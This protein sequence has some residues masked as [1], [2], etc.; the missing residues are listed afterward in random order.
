MQRSNIPMKRAMQL[1]KKKTITTSYGATL[2]RKKTDNKIEKYAVIT[3]SSL[4]QQKQ[5]YDDITML[6][7]ELDLENQNTK[8]VFINFSAKWFQTFENK[9]NE[10][11]SSF[12]DKTD[13]L[14]L[15][16]EQFQ[17][18][19]LHLFEHYVTIQ[20]ENLDLKDQILIEKDQLQD[21]SNELDRL[22][23]QF[24]SFR[25]KSQNENQEILSQ[26]L[27]K[28]QF[29]YENKSL[30]DQIAQINLDYQKIQDQ[31]QILSD[32]YRSLQKEVEEKDDLISN[33]NS[34]IK[35]NEH[36]T[37]VSEMNQQNLVNENK[38][39]KE[40]LELSNKM[41]EM[42]K[43]SPIKSS[44]LQEK[45]EQIENL[46]QT[47][48]SKDLEIEQLK[49]QI[50]ELGNDQNQI[51]K[52]ADQIAL[53]DQEIL[54]LNQRIEELTNKLN[55]GD[56]FQ[57]F[58]DSLSKIADDN[59]Q[60]KVLK[61]Q[62]DQKDE[63]IKEMTNQIQLKDAELINFE[64]T[65][66]ELSEKA[67]LLN[68]L[69]QKMAEMTNEIKI[70]TSSIDDLKGSLKEKDQTIS[71]LTSKLDEKDQMIDALENS[72]VE[73]VE[74]KNQIDSMTKK[75]QLMQSRITE[76]ES[77]LSN[78]KNT[79]NDEVTLLKDRCQLLDLQNEEKQ[80]LINAKDSQIEELTSRQ[81]FYKLKMT[82]AD[83]LALEN[84]NLKTKF[85]EQ[86]KQLDKIQS[87]KEELEENLKL[88]D[89]EKNKISLKLTQVDYDREKLLE[90]VEDYENKFDKNLEEEN[91]QLVQYVKELENQVIELNKKNQK[92]LLYEK[93]IKNYDEEMN[94]LKMML[95]TYKKINEVLQDK[96]DQSNKQNKELLSQMSNESTS[97]MS[98]I[99]TSPFQKTSIACSPF[100]FDQRTD[101]DSEKMNEITAENEKLKKEIENWKKKAVLLKNSIQKAENDIKLLKM[102]CE[103]LNSLIATN[104]Y[105]KSN[106]AKLIEEQE[107]EI[108]RLKNVCER[109]RNEVKQN[110][111]EKN[112]RN[113]SFN[114]VSSELTS[115]RNLYGELNSRYKKFTQQL[116]SILHKETEQ[117]I[118]FN[119]IQLIN[120][121]SCLKVKNLTQ[122]ASKIQ[123]FS[124]A[125]INAI[126]S[127][128][129]S[130]EQK[131]EFVNSELSRF[132]KKIELTSRKIKLQ[133][134]ESQL[135]RKVPATEK[136][137]PLLKLMNRNLIP[138]PIPQKIP[139]K[140][141][142]NFVRRDNPSNFNDV[143][144]SLQELIF[145]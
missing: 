56:S 1:P 58:V 7:K 101:F 88:I 40:K 16:I 110:E 35:S 73:N 127:F 95:D 51:E 47:I 5:F 32:S 46:R 130:I 38:I 57:E 126:D 122:L 124:V 4:Q 21:K 31:Y 61:E 72:E 25:I 55:Q 83:Q 92:G 103:R 131:L 33:L 118:I 139:T 102:E 98:Q 109:L 116:A 24:E 112:E 6:K 123:Y 37:A 115:T 34:Q 26:Q 125:H 89:D 30:Q 54:S 141:G 135:A 76:L 18:K 132:D 74:M 65:S 53:K 27:S 117:E 52:Y 142:Q 8:E 48:N 84:D 96:L 11:N 94:N 128:F 134:N 49:S 82:E 13:Y 97:Q 90:K 75:M 91:K 93:Q 29:E 39:L 50:F 100:K 144:L 68:D 19:F 10:I 99:T 3:A 138:S 43:N 79:Y 17:S 22:K 86:K 71:N 78:E 9:I 44:E 63:M 41:T 121:T 64:K 129:G 77:S 119:V 20:K 136:K 67:F 145:S 140:N 120:S 59:E 15:E 108:S 12:N 80:S 113:K 105:D 81:S 143:S 45:S 114:K 36:F 23:L 66:K 111:E 60:T 69:Q 62:I 137:K 70:K 85:D 14:G 107:K 106:N 2:E 133:I 42:L 28:Q 104:E 87:E